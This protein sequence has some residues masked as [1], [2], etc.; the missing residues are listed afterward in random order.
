MNGCCKIATH[1][2]YRYLCRPFLWKAELTRRYATE[3]N[4]FYSARVRQCDTGTVTIC[5]HLFLLW[6]RF[7]VTDYRTDRMQHIL[8][9]QVIAF[10]YFCATHRLLVSLCPHQSVTLQTQLYACRRVDGIVNAT[11]QWYETT[12]QGVVSCIDNGIRLQPGD[13]S[14]PYPKPVV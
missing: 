9:R 13:V 2:I 4:V 10:G 5:Q 3:S 7:P 14:L 12:Q 1:C 11:M 6:R 8:R